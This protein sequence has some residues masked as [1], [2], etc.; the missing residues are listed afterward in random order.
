[1]VIPQLTTLPGGEQLPH[2]G[3]VRGT[4]SGYVGYSYAG[5]DGL[6]RSFAA[7]HWHG[8]VDFFLG[9]QGGQEL[10]VHLAPRRRVVYLRPTVT[11]ARGAFDLQRQLVE[12]FTI[13]GPFRAILGV[14]RTAGAALTNLGAGWAEPGA[15]GFWDAPTAVE[16]RVLLLEDVSEWPDAPG[17]ESLALRFGTRLDLAFG[18]SGDRH[19]DR[20]GP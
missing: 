13:A 5:E 6:W 19:L 17:V 3:T 14:A 11:W 20:A 9:D 1:M 7:V 2:L 10:N 15:S 12:R 4:S 18:G 8:G 16:Q